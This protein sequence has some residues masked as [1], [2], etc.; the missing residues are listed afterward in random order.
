VPAAADA[1][2]VQERRNDLGVVDH[3]RIARAQQFGQIADRAVLE[4]RGLA[5]AHEQ[6]ARGVTRRR[7]P[8]RNAILRQDEVKQIGAHASPRRCRSCFLQ[9]PIS[10]HGQIGA[11]KTSEHDLKKW[12]LSPLFGCPAFASEQ[13][14][15]SVICWHHRC[16]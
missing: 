8:Q 3:Q 12:P 15:T 9:A 7:G 13:A 10:R 6:E 2:A 5:G 4:L 16:S 14:E 11:G 1:A